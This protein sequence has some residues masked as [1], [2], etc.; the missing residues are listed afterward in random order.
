MEEIKSEPIRH[1][2]H[3]YAQDECELDNNWINIY[4]KINA[5]SHMVSD[6]CFD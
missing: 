1:S 2:T 6:V 4:K 5:I 3:G